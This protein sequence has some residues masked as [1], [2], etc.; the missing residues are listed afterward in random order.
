M[1]TYP[2]VDFSDLCVRVQQEN[3]EKS[4]RILF[5]S[6]YP[7]LFQ[8]ALK[9]LKNT[10]E[11]EEVVMDV[12]MKFWLGRS[13]Q[14]EIKDVRGYFFS[15]VKNQSISYL[16]MKLRNEHLGLDDID[17]DVCRY[18][19]SP[20]K[21]FISREEVDKINLSIAKLPSRCKMILVLLREQQLK[22]KQVADIMG[23]TVKTVENQMAIAMKKIA[24]DLGI[25]LINRQKH[26]EILL[27]VFL[28]KT[29]DCFGGFEKIERRYI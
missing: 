29:G 10:Q 25:D 16:R 12:F 23:I 27:F 15:A 19:W 20:E 26:G 3:C 9:I 1:G 7:E 21:D 11:T 18:D 8:F 4:F 28:I 24:D 6:L 22:Y 2:E 14:H 17:V 13:N 5:D